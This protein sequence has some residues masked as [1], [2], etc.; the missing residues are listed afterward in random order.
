MKG[1]EGFGWPCMRE[2]RGRVLGLMQ[3]MGVGYGVACLRLGMHVEVVLP[4]SGWQ[5]SHL[6]GGPGQV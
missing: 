4:V 5:Q 2:V 1:V 3:R 6:R